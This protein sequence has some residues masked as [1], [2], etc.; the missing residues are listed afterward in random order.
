MLGFLNDSSGA[1][2]QDHHHGYQ[3]FR[4]F[5]PQALE[6]IHNFYAQKLAYLLQKLDSVKESNGTLLD[7]TLVVALT[8]IQMPESHGQD[9][10]PFILAGKAGGKLKS[11]RWLQVKSQPHNNLLVS[12]LNM[13]GLPDE[14]FGHPDYCTGPLAGL[15]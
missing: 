13:F 11:Q 14:T 3:H 4:G 12:I 7:N 6:I 1:P 2:L 5:Q 15:A 9:N 10:M 8:E